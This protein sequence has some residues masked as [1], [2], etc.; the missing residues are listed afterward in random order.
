MMATASRGGTAELVFA[1]C[2]EDGFE[3]REDLTFDL[4][5]SN[6]IYLCGWGNGYFRRGSLQSCGRGPDAI[7]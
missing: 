4:F 1:D 6:S 2:A 3:E 5:I 7:R